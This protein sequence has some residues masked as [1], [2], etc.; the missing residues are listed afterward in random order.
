M[1]WDSPAIAAPRVQMSQCLESNS[2]AAIVVDAVTDESDQDT[3]DESTP[4]AIVPHCELPTLIKITTDLIGDS[5]LSPFSYRSSHV[6]LRGP[7]SLL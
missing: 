6:P 5:Q 4:D 7:P 1:L 2:K 3:P